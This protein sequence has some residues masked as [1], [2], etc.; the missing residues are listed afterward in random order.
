MLVILQQKILSFTNRKQ[1]VGV[2]VIIKC[3]IMISAV[4]TF[5]FI[6]RIK[7]ILHATVNG[8]DASI[9][10]QSFVKTLRC[11]VNCEIKKIIQ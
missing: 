1:K 8:S 10:I 6:N 7:I 2:V 5:N 3:K 11:D 9:Q 4:E